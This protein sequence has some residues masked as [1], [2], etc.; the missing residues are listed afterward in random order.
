[1]L[2][3]ILGT[4]LEQQARDDL[5]DKLLQSAAGRRVQRT[6]QHLAV[7]VFVEDTVG[8]QRMKMKI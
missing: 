2:G 1:M 4:Q 7:R 5:A 6:K 3:Q 8:N